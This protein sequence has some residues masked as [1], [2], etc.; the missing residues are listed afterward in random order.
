MIVN[1][2]E[3]QF[4]TW[5]GDDISEVTDEKLA[6]AADCQGYRIWP[7]EDPNWLGASGPKVCPDSATGA[8]ALNTAATS[9]DCDRS[10]IESVM[11]VVGMVSFVLFLFS[12]CVAMYFY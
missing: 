7:F 12:S 1:N 2:P 11:M 9:C 3:F 10:D 8:A 4:P 5:A 6:T